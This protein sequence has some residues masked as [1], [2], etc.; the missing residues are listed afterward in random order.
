M[1]EEIWKD[2]EGFEG[3]YQVSNKGRVR[4]LEH[5]RYNG[6][7]GYI[8]KSIIRK[9]CN[10]KTYSFIRLSKNGIVKTFTVHKLVANAFLDR[11]KNKNYINHKDGNKHNNY[12]ENLEWCTS[13]EN[14]RHALNTGLR[15][16]NA[17]SIKILQLDKSGNTIKIWESLMEASRNTNIR[18]SGI[19]ACINK[20]V[21]YAGGYRWLKYAESLEESEEK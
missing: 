1:E 7:N 14:Q 13:S 4:S 2:I 5:F 8:Q 9:I 11:P 20:K 16:K 17:K 10:S 12:V 21:N 18:E 15:N 6:Q 19:S 3:Y